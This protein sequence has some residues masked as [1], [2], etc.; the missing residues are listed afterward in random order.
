MN[1]SRWTLIFILFI[2]YFSFAQTGLQKR[3]DD[4]I[5]AN[6]QRTAITDVLRILASQNNLNM[7][8]SDDV[9]GTVTVQLTN[10][11]LADALNTILKSLGYHYIVQNDILLVV[12][13]A[14]EVNGELISRV[15]K[16][17]YLDGFQLQPV[18]QPLL[19][20]KGKVEALVSQIVKETEDQRSDLI[21]VTDVWENQQ[22]IEKVIEE[23]DVQ[24]VQLQI[25][26]KLVE[27]V[28]G[29]NKQVGINW[30]K[31]VNVGITGGELTAPITQASNS[32][33]QQPRYLSAWYE[34]PQINDKLTMGVLTVDEFNAYLELLARD[35]RTHLVSNPKILALNNKKAVINVGTLQPV[36]EV[37]RGVGGD[38]V[39]YKDKEVS[40]LVEV[41]PRVNKDGVILM[42][43]HPKME[44]I[45]GYVGTTDFPQPVIS[46]REVNTDV[47]VREGETVAI[48]GLIKDI[49]TKNVEKL[50][51]LGDIPVL[52]YLFRHTTIRKE[53]SDLLIFITP[54]IQKSL[55]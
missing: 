18:L 29:A 28:I 51:L 22:T 49:Q 40:M 34:L 47:T 44:E 15:Y 42:S 32:S 54:K 7:I 12:P 24:P 1:R 2:S 9:K 25:E 43:V 21:V 35:D 41:T 11:T 26:V 52:G 30:P 3:L 36:P 46:R 38:L 31:K 10:V 33:Q 4:H 48:G 45:T 55:N 53:K 27:T 13:F 6:F 5:S 8:V 19:S 23:M 17:K 50:W 14:S 39:T 37:S 20:P 16:L